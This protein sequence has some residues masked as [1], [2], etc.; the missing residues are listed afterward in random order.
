MSPAHFK[1]MVEA[2]RMP[3]PRDAMGVTVW[4]RQEVEEALFALEVKGGEVEEN[5]CDRLFG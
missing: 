2:G 1:K 3:P 4:L 5:T